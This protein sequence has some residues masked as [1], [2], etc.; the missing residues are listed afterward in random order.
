M[1]F[2]IWNK[3][4]LGLDLS[5]KTTR[6]LYVLYNHLLGLYVLNKLS[7]MDTF[8]PT[9]LEKCAKM[10]YSLHENFEVFRFSKSVAFM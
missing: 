7:K 8:Y 2:V 4:G 10:F 5:R 6:L 9:N 1:L 3:Y